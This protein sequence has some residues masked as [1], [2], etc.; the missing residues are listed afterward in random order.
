MKYSDTSFQELKFLGHMYEFV[1]SLTECV[2]VMHILNIYK[3]NNN[4]AFIVSKVSCLFTNCLI[5]PKFHNDVCAV[6]VRR[7]LLGV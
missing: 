2:I 4:D 7:D 3:D 6:G 5:F 1:C